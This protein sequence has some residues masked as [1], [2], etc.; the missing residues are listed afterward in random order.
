M[1]PIHA[2]VE[3]EGIDMCL[4]TAMETRVRQQ[5]SGEGA[6]RR[7][8]RLFYGLVLY[9]TIRTAQVTPEVNK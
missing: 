9:S 7:V 3:I 8:Q 5:Y 4:Q 6:V 1:N 2:H